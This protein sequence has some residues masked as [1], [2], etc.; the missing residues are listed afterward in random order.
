MGP[1]RIINRRGLSPVVLVCDH[2][3]NR[4]PTEFATL[5]LGP[6]ALHSHIAWG[7]GALAV[8]E[9]MSARLDAALVVSTVS[10]LVVDSNRPLDAVDLIPEKSDETIVPGNL[11]LDEAAR[12]RRIAFAHAPFHQAIEGLCAE[13]VRAGNAPVFVAIHSFTPAYDGKPRP[14]HVDIIHDEDR[15]LADPLAAA[16]AARPGLVVGVNDPYSPSDRVYYTLHRHA[17]SKGFMAVM[18][19]IRNDL[20]ATPETSAKWGEILSSVLGETLREQSRKTPSKETKAAFAF[21]S[22]KHKRALAEDYAAKN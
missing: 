12:H 22:E 13:R 6:S 7:P 5:G 21:G 15:R 16:L 8:V 14:W 9:T 11:G 10:R 19:E 1:V 18:I 4:M 2:A 20:L 3:S 17:S